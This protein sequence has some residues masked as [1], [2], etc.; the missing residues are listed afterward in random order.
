MLKD[1]VVRLEIKDQR[2]AEELKGIVSSMDGFRLQDSDYSRSSDLLILELGN[3]PEKD[4]Q[5]L[6]SIKASGS[7]RQVF[8]TS[9]NLD[10]RILLE[11]RKAGLRISSLN[12]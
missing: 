6:Y 12:P 11:T 9:A 5:L 8:L 7:T 2:V 10:C 3:D 4:F 1:I